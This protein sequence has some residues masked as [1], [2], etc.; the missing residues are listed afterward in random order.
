MVGQYGAAWVRGVQQLDNPLGKGYVKVAASPK[1]FTGYSLEMGPTGGWRPGGTSHWSRSNYTGK[2]SAFD[3][4]DTYLPPWEGA[5]AQGGALGV[6]CSYDGPN[7]IPSCGNKALQV[8]VLQK[9][10]GL[11]GPIVTDC[12]AI[13]GMLC[14]LN[15]SATP[16]QAVADA[17]K[18]RPEQTRVPL[19]AARTLNATCQSRVTLSLR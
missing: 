16:E 18:A 8:D 9:Q 17:I 15:F 14:S 1:H 19:F 2:I 5:I 7:G 6:M 11:A 12:G 3:L 13:P 4:E 10:Y